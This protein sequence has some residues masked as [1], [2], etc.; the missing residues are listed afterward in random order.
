MPS[1]CAASGAAGMPGVFPRRGVC[2]QTSWGVP[3]DIVGCAHRHRGVC[4]RTPWGVPRD[5]DPHRGVCPRVRG[6]NC[7]GCLRL[8]GCAREAVG[9][10]MQRAEGHPAEPRGKGRSYARGGQR[11]RCTT[12]PFLLAGIRVRGASTRMR[13]ARG[14]K[15]TCTVPHAQAV[16]P[17][18][19]VGMWG[20]W[21]RLVGRAHTRA[22]GGNSLGC[23]QRAFT[24]RPRNSFLG[25]PR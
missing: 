18:A 14:I 23:R 24:G 21:A 7:A 15:V 2:P 22:Q 25:P 20:L 5:V 13:E 10:P 8:G 4:P 3:T 11:N 1:L 9:K 12:D 16:F 6:K 19:L 17:H